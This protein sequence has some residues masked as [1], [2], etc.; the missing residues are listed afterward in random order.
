MITTMLSPRVPLYQHLS[1]LYSYFLCA[2]LLSIYSFFSVLHHYSHSATGDVLPSTHSLTV[3]PNTESVKSR[4][5]AN[6]KWQLTEKNLGFARMDGLKMGN[7]STT[8]FFT[9]TE[10]EAHPFRPPRCNNTL[11]IFRA[12]HLLGTISPL[13]GIH[14]LSSKNVHHSA[15]KEHREC[16][17]RATLTCILFLPD[18]FPR[19]FF[20]QRMHLSK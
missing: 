10:S 7:W 6:R 20:H 17:Y 14:C 13:I 1:W 9:Y 4:Q 8:N 5:L 2:L 19:P 18:T 11:F 16:L 3:Q 12:F 15:R